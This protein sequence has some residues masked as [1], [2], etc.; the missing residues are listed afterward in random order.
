MA[1]RRAA[2][3]GRSAGR[4]A[5][6]RKPL[7]DG[8]SLFLSPQLGPYP[9]TARPGMQTA[10]QS[11]R[12]EVRRRRPRGPRTLPS[13]GGVGRTRS[14]GSSR[15]PIE[16]K[17]TPAS[18]HLSIQPRP[19]PP[20]PLATRRGA[21]RRANGLPAAA[22]LLNV[23]LF[24]S[25]HAGRARLDSRARDESSRLGRN[26]PH[27]VVKATLAPEKVPDKGGRKRGRR[28]RSSWDPG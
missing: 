17:V 16:L 2:S 3:R 15:R 6:A 14:T 4:P 22:P 25:C 26:T 18:V 13:G 24:I 10:Q 5:L 8:P 7:P 11:A 12:A 19:Q 21:S 1:Q 9:A 20:A 27:D 28:A 23:V